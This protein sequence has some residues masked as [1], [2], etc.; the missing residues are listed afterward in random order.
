MDTIILLTTVSW[1][2]WG[3]VMIPVRRVCIARFLPPS[4]QPRDWAGE[5]V[6]GLFQRPRPVDSGRF[7]GAALYTAAAAAR[8]PGRFPLP[9][10]AY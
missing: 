2:H 6:A 9:L 3:H 7:D 1:R 10:R 8:G 4:V 5:A